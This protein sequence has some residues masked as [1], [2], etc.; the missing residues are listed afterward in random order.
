MPYAFEGCSNLSEVTILGEGCH[1]TFYRSSFVGCPE[2]DIATSLQ[3]FPST[4]TLVNDAAFS[5]MFDGPAHELRALKFDA[6][7]DDQWSRSRSKSFRI[8]DHGVE[9]L[10]S[11]A[12]TTVDGQAVQFCIELNHDC[13]R[14]YYAIRGAPSAS[15]Q[16]PV[17]EEGYL[18]PKADRFSSRDPSQKAIGNLVGDFS[19]Y[20]Y[21][22]HLTAGPS[23]DGT[24]AAFL[25]DAYR[26]SVIPLV[27]E[28]RRVAADKSGQGRKFEEHKLALLDGLHA[29]IKSVNSRFERDAS[30]VE[31]DVPYYVARYAGTLGKGLAPSAEAARAKEMV[32]RNRSRARSSFFD[33][34]LSLCLR[35]CGWLVMLAIYALCAIIVCMGLLMLLFI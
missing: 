26:T 4:V 8:V 3:N 19:V 23:I 11:F 18:E 2:Q 1:G 24:S 20:L 9:G 6:R 22:C 29:K 13:A 14:G 28:Y 34:L 33:G 35:G 17:L 27:E 25:E 30:L 32:K 12:G 31:L 15:G 10:N 7:S 21:H 5:E 16:R